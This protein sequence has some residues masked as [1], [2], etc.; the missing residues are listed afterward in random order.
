M[1]RENFAY[2][3]KL[4]RKFPNF[5][6]TRFLPKHHGANSIRAYPRKSSFSAARFLQTGFLLRVPR[7][8]LGVLR[9]FARHVLQQWRGAETDRVFHSSGSSSIRGRRPFFS[10]PPS[11][12][13]PRGDLR[14][15]TR[16]P[17]SHGAA[18]NERPETGQEALLLLLHR[19]EALVRSSILQHLFHHLHRGA[20]VEEH[21]QA[22]DHLPSPPGWR[23]RTF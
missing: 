7:S 19:Q 11:R 15:H 17:R 10:R 18:R 5:Q 13:P 12:L 21:C 16:L 1:S 9:L 8:R 22:Q 4:T 6:C 20:G 14:P 3:K 2:R 23:C